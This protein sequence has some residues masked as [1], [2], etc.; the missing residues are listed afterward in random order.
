VQ[1]LARGEEEL[2]LGDFFLSY[3]TTALPMDAV[4]TRVVMP[5]QAA[6]GREL[7]KTYK[8]AKRKDDDIAIVTAGL[9]VRLGVGDVVEEVCL[10]Y[11]GSVGFPPAGA[12]GA[13]E[14]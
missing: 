11:G 14:A 2:Y 6:S 12:A 7:V 5:L 1:S 8:Q 3:R 4:I 9:M 10:A 13:D